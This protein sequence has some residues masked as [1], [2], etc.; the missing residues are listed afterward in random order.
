MQKA[1]PNSWWSR[2]GC[3]TQYFLGLLAIFAI[4]VAGVKIG[5]LDLR[6]IEPPRTFDRAKCVREVG[7]HYGG[8]EDDQSTVASICARRESEALYGE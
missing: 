7:Q 6:N 5:V 4:F 3:L 1:N 8:S 2:Q